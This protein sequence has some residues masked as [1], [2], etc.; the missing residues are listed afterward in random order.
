MNILNWIIS[1]IL[2][3]NVILSKFLGTCPFIGIS[4]NKKNALEMGIVV[5]IIMTISSILSWF[6]YKYILIKFDLLY[7][8]TII[9][10]LIISSFVQMIEMIIK[11]ISP[12]LYSNLGIYLPL[13]TT[14]CAVLGIATSVCNYSFIHALITSFASG[15]GFLFTI[16]I[17][18]SLREKLDY[19]PIPKS[20]KGVP[21]AL[22]TASIMAMII[23]RLSGV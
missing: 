16:Y 1:G 14:N 15:I 6:I 10:V 7:M 5:M 3:E 11:K 8:K 13:I 18:S 22:I 12:I 4:K 21:I 19:A 2:L 17:F 9:F 20:F 23:F